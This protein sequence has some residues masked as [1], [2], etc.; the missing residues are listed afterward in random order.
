M[1]ANSNNSQRRT[2]HPDTSRRDQ[3]PAASGF[4]LVDFISRWR[5]RGHRG[6]HG[7]LDVRRGRAYDDDDEAPSSPL[8]LNRF[9]TNISSPTSPTTEDRDIDDE[10]PYPLPEAFLPPASAASAASIPNAITKASVKDI[11]DNDDDFEEA[12][13]IR[14]YGS[15]QIKAYDRLSSSLPPQ[16]AELIQIEDDDEA[17]NNAYFEDLRGCVNPF[18]LSTICDSG[19][20]SGTKT[21]STSNTSR[22]GRSEDAIELTQHQH[23]HHKNGGGANTVSAIGVGGGDKKQ[24]GDQKSDIS[25]LKRLT[26]FAAKQRDKKKGNR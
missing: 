7:G 13:S 1:A 19:G 20:A 2:S 11:F 4:P 18:P 6:H 16:E 9:S 5:L 26:E 8:L 14:S 12:M 3:D 17:D 21:A 15:E 10:V 24:Q 25:L 22:A 23:Q